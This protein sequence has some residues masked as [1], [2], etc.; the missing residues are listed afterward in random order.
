MIKMVGFDMAKK[1][2]D[3]VYGQAGLGPKDVQV[4]ELHDCFTANELLTYEPV[5]PLWAGRQAR[6]GRGASVSS[7]VA[8][9][10][11]LSASLPARAYE[12][13]PGSAP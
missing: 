2:A 12:V 4:V 3:K 6:R 8:P 9:H 5:R 1:C 10:R 7:A 13:D 11:P